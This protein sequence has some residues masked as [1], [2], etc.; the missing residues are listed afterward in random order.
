MDLGD[1]KA[2]EK[3]PNIV[4]IVSTPNIGNVDVAR[5]AVMVRR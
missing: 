3:R 5:K 4:F 1:I 2:V